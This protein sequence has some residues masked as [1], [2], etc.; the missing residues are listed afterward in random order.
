MKRL[1]IRYLPILLVAFIGL[2]FPISRALADNTCTI[3]YTDS[4]HGATVISGF[5]PYSSGSWVEGQ[6]LVAG[7]SFDAHD[8]WAFDLPITQTNVTSLSFHTNQPGSEFTGAGTTEVIDTSLVVGCWT[9]SSCGTHIPWVYSETLDLGGGHYQTTYNFDPVTDIATK[10]SIFHDWGSHMPHL[11]TVSEITYT[12]TDACT[13]DDTGTLTRPLTSDDEADTDPLYDL[14][15]VYADSFNLDIY[16]TL[17]AG[18]VDSVYG[19]SKAPGAKVHAADAGSIVDVKGLSWDQ[20]GIANVTPIPSEDDPQPTEYVRYPASG[21]QPCLVSHYGSDHVAEIHWLDA[22]DVYIVTLQLGDS[23]KIQY[24]VKNAPNYVV[25][26]DT[27]AA[28]C[29]LGE[30]IPLTTLPAP[31]INYNQLGAIAAVG[32]LFTDGLSELAFGVIGAGSQVISAFGSTAPSNTPL[33]YTMLTFY[34]T[35]DS[36]LEL[37]S[38]L[39][40]EPT[41]DDKCNQTGEFKDC[42][43]FNPQFTNGGDGWVASGNVQW[44]EPGVIL[45]PGQ[46]VQ[47]TI[48]L[49]STG[50]YTATAFAEGVNGAAGELRVFLG[51]HTERFPAPVEWSDLQLDASPLGA[52]DAGTFYT[53]GVQNTG[54]APIQ[55]NSL[56]VTD[57]AP[58][59]GPNSC[60][61]NNQSFVQGTSGWD[62]S[63]GVEPVDQGLNVPDGG[64]ISQNVMLN[65]LPGGAATYHLVVRGNWWYTGAMDT[66][67]SASAIAQIQYEWP[68]GTG[69]VDMVPITI[70]GNLAFG[71]GQLA[72]IAD[73]SVTDTTDAVMNLKVSTTTAGDMGVQG[74]Q[75][76][77][78]CLSTI[79][80]GSFP[81]QGGGGAPPPL[82]ANCTYVSRPQN[83]DPAAWLQWHWEKSNQFF[84]CQLMVLLNKMYTLGKQ[85]Y[86]LAGWEARYMQSQ[87]KLW[88]S[89]LGA[90]LF[91]WL[92]GQFRN[93]AIGQVTTV[94]Q[95]GGSCNDLF[96][97]LNTL[98]SGILTPLNNIVNTLLGLINTAANL[99]LTIITGIIGVALSFLTRIFGI[100]NQATS[101]LTGII[102]A[103][104]TATPVTIDGMPTCSI[105]PTSSPLCRMVWVMDNTAFNGRWGVLFTIALSILTIH[106]ILWAVG[107]FRNAILKMGS[108]S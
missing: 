62:V 20:C 8:R 55:V 18:G 5:E 50:D 101:L 13:G 75:I 70:K 7:D 78:A 100:V 66:T 53:V 102:T 10:L 31:A 57:G 58:N 24:L 104:S 45:G 15:A 94:Y 77:D 41:S 17:N 105:D 99:F 9:D 54:N 72:Y 108:A 90:Q 97:V 19:W 1:V 73:I 81:G 32:A 71:A 68:D 42:L 95:S 2:S 61:F 3:D 91:P 89:W 29:V 69:Y 47:A 21:D 67:S 16:P 64:T 92:N 51:S 35:D 74:I 59:L 52:P 23:T 103:Y 49:T 63:D 87:L 37:A 79:D 12:T 80:G 43:A 44:T 65:P 93:M 84:T 85:S 6:G 48:N 36:I 76:T 4:D 46:S 14:N 33:G 25:V 38:Q 83:N 28:G 96:C 11:F 82:D 40:V 30:T 39:T 22:S 88:S 106:L 34:D 27:V 98:I 56:C 26:G 60:Y 86:L 107:E